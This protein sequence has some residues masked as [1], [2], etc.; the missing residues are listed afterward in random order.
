MRIDTAGSAYTAQFAP[1]S[2]RPVTGG[3][4]VGEALTPTTGAEA[5]PGTRPAPATTAGADTGAAADEQTSERRKEPGATTDVDAEVRARISELA[6]RDREV[7]AH[8]RAHLSAAGGLAVGGMSLETVR[9]PNGRSYAVG[10]E[11]RIDTSPVSG[12]PRAT[13][14]KARQIRRAALAPAEPSTQDRRVAAQAAAMETAARA[15]LALRAD[16]GDASSTATRDD[17]PRDGEDDARA[18]GNA[19]RLAAALQAVTGGE[20]SPSID[21]RA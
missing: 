10:G 6:S 20:P 4:A 13:I 11:V 19:R 17:G 14:D 21:L 8:E 16:A 3:D 12:D 18:N 1:A 9:G 7:R 2:Q 15:E 5:A